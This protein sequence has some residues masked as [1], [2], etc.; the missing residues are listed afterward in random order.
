M[1][2]FVPATAHADDVVPLRAKPSA[3]TM[4]SECG[5]RVYTGRAI[6]VVNVTKNTDMEQGWI[7]LQYCAKS[8]LWPPLI[9]PWIFSTVS[10]LQ[11]LERHTTCLVSWPKII[12]IAATLRRNQLNVAT[13][14]QIIFQQKTTQS[15]NSIQMAKTATVIILSIDKP[16]TFQNIINLKTVFKDLAQQ[17]M[18]TCSS[19]M[20]KKIIS[21]NI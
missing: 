3:G 16:T 13:V 17:C 8:R 11:P 10:A 20:V 6:K 14:Y 21:Q 18:T 15:L 19:Q 1:C 2:N 7:N 12:P 5:S 4:K 9:L